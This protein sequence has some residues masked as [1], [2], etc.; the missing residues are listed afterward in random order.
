MQKCGRSV[1]GEKHL[2]VKKR[3]APSR[4]DCSKMPRSKLKNE[5]VTMSWAES[6]KWVN[7]RKV[8]QEMGH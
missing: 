8:N 2:W 3:L 7:S 4:R 5:S 6:I 1:Q